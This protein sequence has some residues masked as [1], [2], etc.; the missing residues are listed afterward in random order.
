LAR[1][2]THDISGEGPHTL[3]MI[4]QHELLDTQPYPLFRLISGLVSHSH[5]VRAKF[6]AYLEQVYVQAGKNQCKHG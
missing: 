4:Q 1:E 5:Q 2:E 3:K 6:H